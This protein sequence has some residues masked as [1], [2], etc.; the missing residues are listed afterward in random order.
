MMA[1]LR[2][3]R[4]PTVF[5]AMADIFLGFLLVS[6]GAFEPVGSFALLLVCLLYTSDAADE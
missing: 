4:L 6:G 1:W 3:V 2:L 5:T